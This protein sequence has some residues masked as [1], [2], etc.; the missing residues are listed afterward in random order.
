[1]TVSSTK[2]WK[3]RFH[4]DFPFWYP[5]GSCTTNIGFQ[6]SAT[7]GKC[8]FSFLVQLI[9]FVALSWVSFVT[10][11]HSSL[12]VHMVP[13]AVWIGLL[14]VFWQF[15]GTPS[16][17]TPVESILRGSTSY[18]RHLTPGPEM[19]GRLSAIPAKHRFGLE[20]IYCRH[21]IFVT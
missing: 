7:L 16:G 12:V 10:L 1:M 11:R 17:S 3:C 20:N 9:Q 4:G 21:T 15:L 18:S 2:L 13:Y 14:V 8:V 19:G 5:G 6:T